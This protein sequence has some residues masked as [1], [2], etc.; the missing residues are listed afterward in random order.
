MFIFNNRVVA[1][2]W[3]TDYQVWTQTIRQN[4]SVVCIK[5]CIQ[6]P[7]VQLLKMRCVDV[8]DH[9]SQVYGSDNQLT[10]CS[11]LF[12][13]GMNG[14]GCFAVFVTFDNQL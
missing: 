10:V 7:T 8:R 12:F 9:T 14:N 5:I 6:Q 2:G 13:I 11:S 3:T 4:L 1:L